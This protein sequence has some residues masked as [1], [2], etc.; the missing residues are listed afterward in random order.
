MDGSG[1]GDMAY[2]VGGPLL[3]FSN[4]GCDLRM[5]SRQRSS[6]HAEP[7]LSDRMT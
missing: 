7:Q 5:E 2:S 6:T 1:G 4:F 3:C